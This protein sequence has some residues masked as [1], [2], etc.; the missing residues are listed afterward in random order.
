M[1]QKVGPMLVF[2]ALVG[3][4]SLSLLSDAQH[5]ERELFQ[6]QPDKADISQDFGGSITKREAVPLLEQDSDNVDL[7]S[8]KRFSSFRS[9]LGKRSPLV[10]LDLDEDAVE[11]LKR[12]YGF[13]ADLGKRSDD[14]LDLE[15][16]EDKRYSSFRSDLGKRYSGFRSDLGKRYAGFR[17]DLGK[18]YSGFRSDLGKRNYADALNNEE[19]E[20][21]GDADKR[22]SSF[23]ADLGKREEGLKRY[24]FRSDLGKR[25]SRFRSDLGKRPYSSFRAD[26]GKRYS[27]FRA[28]LGKRLSG[29]RADLGK[30]SAGQSTTTTFFQISTGTSRLIQK[31][32]TLQNSFKQSEFGIK[33]AD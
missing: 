2:L 29:F 24:M 11:S 10:D 23:R 3:V 12:A 9:D 18:R 20:F 1:A 25:Y 6:P 30:R 28:D 31:R 21:D 32:N 27:G 26:L 5:I 7:N 19:D 17:A 4:S 16:E 15:D 8:D 22:Y 33:Q 14:D 13:R